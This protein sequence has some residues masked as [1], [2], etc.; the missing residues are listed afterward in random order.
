MESLPQSEQTKAGWPVKAMSLWKKSHPGKNFCT[1]TYLSLNLMQGWYKRA[2]AKLNGLPEYRLEKKHFQGFAASEIMKEFPAADGET[3]SARYNALK[4]FINNCNNVDFAIRGKARTLANLFEAYVSKR[5]KESQMYKS[6]ETYERNCAYT[7][8][9][10]YHPAHP[11][12]LLAIGIYNTGPRAVEM[13]HAT[14]SNGMPMST[15]TIKVGRL[16][17][18]KIS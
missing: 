11:G 16:R 15:T 6:G 3:Q 2:V 13:I 5:S 8:K 10:P 12:W 17:L 14:T 4:A 1:S 9:S 7:W 18:P